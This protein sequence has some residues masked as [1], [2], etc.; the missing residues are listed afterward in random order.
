MYTYLFACQVETAVTCGN[1]ERYEALRK[2]ENKFLN[3]R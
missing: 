3:I 2:R 1:T